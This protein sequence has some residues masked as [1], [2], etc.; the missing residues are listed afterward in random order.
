MSAAIN[1]TPLGLA[2]ADPAP[3]SEE[4]LA[5]G[6]DAVLDLVYAAGGTRWVRRCQAL[7]LPAADGRTML[8]AQGACAF[9]RF[10]PGIPAPREVMAAAV[11]RS[12]A[13]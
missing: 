11:E 12:L 5:A 2:E 6:C 10:F 4:R 1:A 13:P 3:I 9:E 7:G 8:V